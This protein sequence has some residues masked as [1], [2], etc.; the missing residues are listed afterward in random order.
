MFNL[1]AT[2]TRE[3]AQKTAETRSSAQLRESTAEFECHLPLAFLLPFPSVNHQLTA[4][5][6]ENTFYLLIH[7]LFLDSFPREWGRLTLPHPWPLWPEAMISHNTWARVKIYPIKHSGLPS[8]HFNRQG[9][10]CLC[11][12]KIPIIE[13]LFLIALTLGHTFNWKSYW[14][15]E[16]DK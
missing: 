9:H 14:E 10:A 16:K 3:N 12:V 5:S 11:T 13:D 15:N 6:S 8:L 2:T 1:K 7:C 4:Y